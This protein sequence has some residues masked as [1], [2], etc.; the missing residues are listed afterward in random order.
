MKFGQLLEYN[1]K[2]IFLEKSYTKRGGEI[3]LRPFSKKSKLSIPYLL[4]WAPGRSFNFE[5]SKGGAYSREALI[6]YIKETSKCF[7]LVS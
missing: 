2:S 7:Q 6:E 3:I 1:M 5:F 4:E